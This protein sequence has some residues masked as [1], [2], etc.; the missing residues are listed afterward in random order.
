MITARRT[1][2][3]NTSRI[4]R[5][6]WTKRSVSRVEIADSLGLNKSTVTNIVNELI[7]EGFVLPDS[8]GEAGPTGG[9]KPIY[10]GLNKDYGTVIG[11]ELRPESYVAVGVD[12]I[13]DIVFSKSERMSIA[14]SNLRGSFS[15]ILDRIDSERRRGGSPLL[16]IGVGLA[17]IIDAR[18][19]LIRRSIPLQIETDY[20]FFGEI[21]SKQDV[22][23]F[24]ENDANCCAWGELAFHRHR[25][26]ESFLFVLVEF[27]DLPNEM[28]APEKT[29][30]GIG[31]SFEGRVYRGTD[32]SAGEFRS[33][34]RSETHHGQL[35]LD[36]G[37]VALVESDPAVRRKFIRELSKNLA[38]MVNT[39]NFDAVFLG[40]D[41]EKY[42]NEVSEILHEE[43]ER[44]WAYDGPVEC[45]IRFS[46]LGDRAVAYGA[47]GM[48]L[49]RLFM[50][51]ETAEEPG[52]VRFG[53]VD[54]IPGWNKHHAS[55]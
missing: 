37:E 29:A 27:R 12:L 54:L 4:L 3:I 17:G 21:A 16:G 47:A 14:G 8:I 49:D 55:R 18:R 7:D 10:L 9:R 46:T 25:P 33:V 51:P 1:K 11:I 6:L 23:V 28:V 13:G 44:N 20:D 53:G 24:P 5:E 19:Q 38:L 43:I 40:G 41:I 32:S 26:V 35:S 31:I 39:F 15:E 34:L 52:G 45:E 36:P 22:P 30:V 48:M 42:Q 2:I 50:D